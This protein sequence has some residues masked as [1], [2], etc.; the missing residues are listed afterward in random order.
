[1]LSFSSA[2]RAKARAQTFYVLCVEAHRAYRT[3]LLVVAGH[4]LG[5]S[6]AIGQSV[7]VSESC[8]MRQDFLLS[9]VSRAQRQNSR[10]PRSC[11][12]NSLLCEPSTDNRGFEQLLL[13]IGKQP[14]MHRGTQGQFFN[15]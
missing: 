2:K 6:S 1:M 9:F 14:S 3:L 5:T 7:R 11:T 10:C 8:A 15:A 4:S 13:S 12:D